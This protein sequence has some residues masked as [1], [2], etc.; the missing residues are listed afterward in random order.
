MDSFVNEFHQAL[1]YELFEWKQPD[2]PKHELMKGNY[3]QLEPLNWDKHGVDLF[4]ANQLEKD[5]SN[6]TYMY[7][8]PFFDINAYRNWVIASI[9]CKD[10]QFYAIVDLNTNKAVGV[11]S[12]LRIDPVNGCIE[13]GNLYFSPL[14]RNTISSTEAMYLMMCRVF[15]LG[16]RRYEWKCHSMNKPSRMAAQRLGFSFEGIFRQATIAKGRNR[17]TAW[18]SIIDK[19]WPELKK[20]YLKWLDLSNFD[21]DGNQKLKLSELTSSNLKNIC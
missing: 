2:F 9:N 17:D 7:M 4:A 3:C 14:L 15:E 8:G 21:A 5:D 1:S 18:Y 19:E 13:V 12:Y 16:Y 6:W 20:K 10:P 11:S